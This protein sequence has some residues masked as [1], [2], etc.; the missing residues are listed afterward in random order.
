ML[1]DGASHGM[2]SPMIGEEPVV[3]LTRNEP[4]Q[5]ADDVS[6]A[7]TLSRSAHHIVHRGLMPSHAHGD[8]PV[9]RRVGLA[10]A[11]T[12]ESM[13]MRHTARRR[14]RARAA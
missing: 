8:D 11:A 7:E 13:A 12:K 9:E 6:F 4:F 1:L 10:M 3:D 14:N 5:A 2:A